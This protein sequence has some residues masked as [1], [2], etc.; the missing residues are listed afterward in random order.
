MSVF[1]RILLTTALLCG[2]LIAMSATSPH[3]S[4]FGNKELK[5]ALNGVEKDVTSLLQM[6]ERPELPFHHSRTKN[7]MAFLG[8]DKGNPAEVEPHKINGAEGAYWE[9]SLSMGI[10]QIASYMYNPAVPPQAIYPA[11]VRM[12]GWLDTG[13]KK[14]LQPLYATLPDA[15]NPIVFR[16]TEYE[17]TT[18]DVNSGTYFRYDVSRMV[19]GYQ[20]ADG[21]VLLS[22]SRMKG[23]S[24]VGM[25]GLAFGPPQDWYFFYSGIKG[26]LMT[27][28]SWA[29]SQ[30]Y[31]SIS[32]FVFRETAPA[33][34]KASLFKWVK[35]GWKG[36]NMVKHDHILQG[37]KLFS[38]NIQDVLGSASLPKPEVIAAKAAAIA[39]LDEETMRLELQPLAALLE[40]S[41][42]TEKDLQRD[43]FSRL[44]QGGY[45]E[46]LSREDMS[47]ELVKSFIRQSL[48]RSALTAGQR[49]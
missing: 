38:S 26:N 1:F 16:G 4:L 31:D 13:A 47:A 43:E 42:K 17:V 5:D 23:K 48:G 25:K 24:T 32:V 41:A 18:P 34:T 3:A 15:E 45:L 2:F 19:A 36:M 27:G 39:K 28:I 22:I 21:P 11:S 40:S 9:F 7:L 12:G 29:E 49:P 10:N 8:M 20:D 46:T 14:A 37:C 44:V 6:L 30:M 33:K 35:A